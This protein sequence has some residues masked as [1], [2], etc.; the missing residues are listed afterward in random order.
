MLD[1][2]PGIAACVV[3]G[4]P[5][6][7]LGERVA[8]AVVLDDPALTVEAITA[9]CRTQLAKYKVPERFVVVDDLPRNAMS[10]VDR[11][12]VGALFGN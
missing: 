7:R 3:T 6:E 11:K 12:A 9:H 2:M 1:T 5:D 10:K 8:A 4:L